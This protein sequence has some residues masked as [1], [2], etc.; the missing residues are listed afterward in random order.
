MLSRPVHIISKLRE[1]EP[2]VLLEHDHG[3]GRGAYDAR[4]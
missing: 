2:V 1:T 4:E 3:G